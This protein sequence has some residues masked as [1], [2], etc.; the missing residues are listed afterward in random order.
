V[1]RDNLRISSCKRQEYF[2][3][4]D[5]VFLFS[6]YED[7]LA[8]TCSGSAFQERVQRG[9]THLNSSQ[10]DFQSAELFI[11]RVWS[12]TA[13]VPTNA[14]Q[15][16]AGV[17]YNIDTVLDDITIGESLNL[18]NQTNLL[19]SLLTAREAESMDLSAA[20]TELEKF[21]KVDFL[22]N[23]TLFD[24]DLDNPLSLSS[25]VTGAY[26]SLAFILMLLPILC[27]CTCK[28]FRK[29]A[30][31]LIKNVFKFIWWLLKAVWQILCGLVAYGRARQEEALCA[32]DPEASVRFHSTDRDPTD[33][34]AGPAVA[35][36]EQLTFETTQ[37]FESRLGARRRVPQCWDRELE[38]VLEQ[39]N[40]QAGSSPRLRTN[41][42]GGQ[43]CRRILPFD[44]R[45]T[46]WL[47]PRFE[48]SSIPS[49]GSP[50]DRLASRDD[51][52]DRQRMFTMDF[53]YVVQNVASQWRL[54]YL[55]DRSIRLVKGIS[56]E[57]LV[58]DPQG[59]SVRNASGLEVVCEPP[60]PYVL[61]KFYSLA[62]HSQVA[63]RIDPTS[64]LLGIQ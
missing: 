35:G 16:L 57:T 28:C 13:V 12:R 48:S 45:S 53:S 31:A 43:P 14:T 6:P 63:S 59:S 17:I 32:P 8:V 42:F 21:K 61:D 30:Q 27:C 50:A 4:G 58:F 37:D 62:E 51:V 64:K 36:D 46:E 26:I 23:Y 56:F 33:T 44:S 39:R 40:I 49:D 15:G 25:S 52:A 1:C 41:S 38:Q 20:V 5:S 2:R 29:A 11:T 47:A 3:R 22:A 9:I 34:S 10:C 18:L 55:T 24:F 60:E 7:V 54:E 19:S